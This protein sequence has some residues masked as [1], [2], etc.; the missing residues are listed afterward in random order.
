M[1]KFFSISLFLMSMCFVGCNNDEEVID[2]A[3]YNEVI[4]L[5]GTQSYLNNLKTLIGA[6]ETRTVKEDED[7]IVPLIVEESIKYLNANKI[8]YKEFFEDDSDPRIAVFVMG[9]VEIEK[10]SKMASFTR[11]TVMGC[12]LQAVG[13][14]DLAT[15]GLTNAAV[16]A[17]GKAVAKKAIPYVGWGLFAIDMGMCLTE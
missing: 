15:K 6:P 17:L 16:K 12:V 1:K 5:V 7:S 3:S 2:N 8:D 14:K 11:T 13:V 9:I 10:T 4:E